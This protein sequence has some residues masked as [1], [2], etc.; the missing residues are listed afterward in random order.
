MSERRAGLV[1]LIGAPNAGKSTL[2]NRMVGARLAP[3]TRK[4]QTTRTRLRGIRMEGEAQII[5]V[6]TPGLFRPGRRLDRAMVA[7][8]WAGAGDADITAVL[9][10][11]R[12]GVTSELR[13]TI[14]EMPARLPADRPRVL[15]LNKVDLVPR[16]QLLPLSAELNAL[17]DFAAS[18]MISAQTGSGTEV[19]ARWLAGRLPAGPWLF[20][21][22]QIGDVPLRLHAAELTRETLMDRLHDELPYELTVEPETW[23]ERSDG[24]VRITQ[25]IMVA[26]SAHRP[27]ILGRGGRTIAAIGKASRTRIG[28][29]LGREAH[30]SL[31]VRVA[32]RWQDDRERYRAIGLDFDP[33]R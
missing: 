18:F 24:S 27:I 12:R 1:A 31:D 29:F 25:V 9:V 7:A 21:P 11:A 3:V 6:D 13:A 5:F 19:L 2:L 14:A 23:Q 20:P 15:I 22:D 8:A 17:G 4:V 33:R 10:D 28:A 16:A 32:P 26:R 30:L